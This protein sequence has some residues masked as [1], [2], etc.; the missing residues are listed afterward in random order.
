MGPFEYR[1]PSFPVI[2]VTLR[3]TRFEVEG[4]DDEVLKYDGFIKQD[5]SLYH[6]VP[7]V[8]VACS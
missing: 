4:E 3:H 6:K 2:V 8:V 1:I 5:P 7:G